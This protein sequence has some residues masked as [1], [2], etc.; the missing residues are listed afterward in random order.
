MI[1]L[2]IMNKENE[3]CFI[4]HKVTMNLVGPENLA[5]SVHSMLSPRPALRREKCTRTYD[6][7]PNGLEM[8]PRTILSSAFQNP[9]GKN[10]TPSN[11]ASQSIP[12]RKDEYSRTHTGVWCRSSSRKNCHLRI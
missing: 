2:I 9:V 6:E 5:T 1:Q 10:G 11:A 4:I 8:L 12:R 7:N 3:I